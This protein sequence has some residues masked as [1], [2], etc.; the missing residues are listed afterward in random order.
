MKRLILF[1]GSV[2]L[3]VCSF[4][5]K[6]TRGPDLGEVYFLG[7]SVTILD[8]AI[9]RSVDFGET[10]ICMDSISQANSLI[11]AISA[12]KETGNVYFS[13]ILENLYHSGNYGQAGTWVLK[14]NNVYPYLLSGVSSGYVFEYCMKHSEEFGNSFI[15]HALN[16]YFGVVI[17]SEL[18]V[19]NGTGYAILKFWGQNDTL[20]FMKS[21]DNF[22]NLE[23]QNKFVESVDPLNWLS[24]G[25]SSG[26]LFSFVDSENSMVRFS[27][28]FSYSWETKNKLYL[29]NYFN[30]GFTGG[31]QPGEL[32][33]MVTYIQLAGQIKHIYI[34]YSMDY[35][36]SFTIYHPFSY[37]F[38]TFYVAFKAS[39]Y[40]GNVPLTVNFYDGSSGEDISWEWDFENDGII[41][42]YEQNP[43][44]TFYNTGYF[45]IKL[46]VT[47]SP[48]FCD[49][50]IK[51]DYIYV[52]DTTTNIISKHSVL[53]IK[54][55]PNP[56]LDQI[57][58]KINTDCADLAHNELY[59]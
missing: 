20:Y 2:L 35:G 5:Q 11:E 54:T 10:A 29:N 33:L 51:L 14:S 26:E 4:T 52:S 44:Y 13:T 42:S 8:Q 7:P 3:V 45:S 36:N 57:T 28:D 1:T 40:T 46:K 19:Q 53:D 18:D 41:D 16:G 38:A 34:Y 48:Y 6:I 55:F 12:D 21:N 9:Y 32:Y 47:G 50:I 25:Y 23:L 31:R 39:T 15:N 24:R 27:N 56:F 49:S 30:I 37:G 59:I 17:S 43:I 22:E 58:I